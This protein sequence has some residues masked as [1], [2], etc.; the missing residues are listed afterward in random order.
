MRGMQ[1]LAIAAAL[2][3]VGAICNWLY[4]SRLA[5]DLDK[6]S[7]VFTKPG[8]QINHGDVFKASDFQRVD[9][10]EAYLGNLE[11]VGVLWQDVHTI[12]GE[13]AK[14]TYR[15][16]EILLE[17]DLKTPT[18]RKLSEL[19][20]ENEVVRWVS[21][22]TR[23]F[24]SNNVDP[25][26]MVSFEVS[27]IGGTTAPRGTGNA[28]APN[29]E[30]IGPFRILQI[31][32]RLDPRDVHRAAGRSTGSEHSI[33]IAVQFEKNKLDP[34]ADRLFDALRLSGNKGANVLLH[35]SRKKTSPPPPSSS[36]S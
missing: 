29:T 31:G 19:I 23:S 15:G 9:I 24:Q 11:K 3:V 14:K 33:A 1:G 32:Q 22:D 17:E 2:G 6:V 20:G 16:N 5:S 28:A 27:S 34:K 4:I 30:I 7:F 26:D 13:P 8:V 25:G 12:V 36:G 21:V 35:S 18:A 10:P